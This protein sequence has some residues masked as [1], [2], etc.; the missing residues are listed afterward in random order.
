MQ[1]WPPLRAEINGILERGANEKTWMLVDAYASAAARWPLAQQVV[2]IERAWNEL[3]NND[4][5]SE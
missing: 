2:A 1:C 3:P 4:D 5:K